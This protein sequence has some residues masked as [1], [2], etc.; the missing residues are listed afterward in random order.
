LGPQL[1]PPLQTEQVPLSPLMLLL[2]DSVGGHIG[3][4]HF[5][6]EYYALPLSP[7]YSISLLVLFFPPPWHLAGYP[8][9]MAFSRLYCLFLFFS[10]L[11]PQIPALEGFPFQL[12]DF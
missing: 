9:V 1:P 2:P 10:D 7:P 3:R 4:P 5:L 12:C 6:L 8:Q 11:I